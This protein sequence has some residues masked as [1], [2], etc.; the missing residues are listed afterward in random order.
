[1]H[2]VQPL[3]LTLVWSD[4]G[5]ACH[6]RSIHSMPGGLGVHAG[7]PRGREGAVEPPVVGVG[8]LGVGDHVHAKAIAIHAGVG[9]GVGGV[10]G[11]HVGDVMLCGGVGVPHGGLAGVQVV[12]HGALLLLVVEGLRSV[13]IM[14][15]HGRR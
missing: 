7:G 2:A 12:L 6:T 5:H 13:M 3:L 1:M 4:M 9:G 14:T 11:V 8:H 15:L 10:V